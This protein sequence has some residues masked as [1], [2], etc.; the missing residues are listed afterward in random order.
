M[1][2]TPGNLAVDRS[3]IRKVKFKYG[4][5]EQVPDLIIFKTASETYKLQATGSLRPIKKTLVAAGIT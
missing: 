2:E 1:A 3:D 4:S 5:T